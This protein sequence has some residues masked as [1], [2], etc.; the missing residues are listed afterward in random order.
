MGKLLRD[1]LRRVTPDKAY[2]ELQPS[3]QSVVHTM[4]EGS[5]DF[6]RLFTMEPFQRLLGLFGGELAAQNNKTIMDA[7]S[8]TAGTF[9]D[10][11][12][13][14]NL[15]HVARRLHDSLDSLSFDDERRQLGLLINAFVRK[16]DFGR[17]FEQQLSFFVD[18]RAA[19]ANLDAVKDT[20][21]LGVAALAMRTRSHVRGRHSKRTAG[22]VKACMAF[23]FITIPSIESLL[24]RFNLYLLGAQASLCNHLLPQMEAFV[25]A[26]VTLPP[27]PLP[28]PRSLRDGRVA[29]V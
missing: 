16:I 3:L 4:L 19:F 6:G 24:L 20:L 9:S 22:F 1:I 17:D 29:A 15:T 26:A 2:L 18:C 13:I 14:N 12:L 10:P 25:K 28:P 21:V 11:V 8:K 23:A 27:P 5:L 7:F